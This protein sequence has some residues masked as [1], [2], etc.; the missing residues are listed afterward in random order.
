MD[1]CLGPPFDRELP[2]LVALVALFVEP[3]R[4]LLR[5][6]AGRVQQLLARQ[7]LADH[8][9]AEEL[10]EMLDDALGAE[11]VAERLLVPGL[12]RL[13]KRRSRSSSDS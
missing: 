3:R 2:L 9:V 7:H 10:A 12:E 13:S 11:E 8:Q 6:R 5:H 1:R 4:E